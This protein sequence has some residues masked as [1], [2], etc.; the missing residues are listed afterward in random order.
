MSVTAEIQQATFRTN[1]P[2]R[3]DRLPWSRWHW[4]LILALGIT[5]I[6]DGLEVTLVGAVSPVL[7]RPDT[8]GFSSTQNGLL[9]AAYLCGAVV[10]S[11]AFGYLTDLWGRK[12]LFTVTLGLYAVTAFLTAFSWDFVSFAFFRFLTGAAIG[13]EYSAINSAIDELIPARLRGR[14]D[15]AVNGTF[16]IGFATGSLATIVLLDAHYFPINVGWRLGFGIGAALSLIIIVFRT[17]VPESPRWLMTRGYRA[18]AERVTTEIE[19]TIESDRRTTKLPAPKGSITI[20]PHGP[21]GLG[22]IA[23][24]LL[25]KYPRRTALGVAMIMAQAF[26]YNGV[27]FTFALI[28]AK[29]YGVAVDR[30]GL[31]LMPFALGNFLGPLVLG[32]LFDRLG[33][34]PMIAGTYAVSATLLVVTGFLFERDVLSPTT[35]TLAWGMIFFFA[36]AAASS[37]YLTVSEIFPLEL[38]GLA[39]A[40]FYSTGTALGGPLASWLF[41]RLIDKGAR[42]YVLYG[43]VLAG[44][45]LIGTVVVVLLFGVKAERTS[46]EDVAEPL[47]AASDDTSGQRAVSA[48]PGGDDG[49]GATASSE[50]P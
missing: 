15:L 22:T 41:G 43:D 21:I 25:R 45:I 30:I 20:R 31:Y 49:S 2:S 18:E 16:W 42:I 50:T 6:I 24:V 48:P 3:L 35:Q 5:W 17:G 14:V 33:R 26:L 44:F 11:L 38:R 37:A 32:P 8:L 9:N 36:S 27:S 23:T 13:G 29:F 1:I 34:K 28:L 10:G 39:I 4:R 12:R 47:S 7:Q 46:L 40:L 19:R